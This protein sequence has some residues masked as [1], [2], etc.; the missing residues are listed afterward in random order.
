M[1]KMCALLTFTLLVLIF[2]INTVNAQD[3]VQKNWY[4]TYHHAAPA[5]LNDEPSGLVFFKDNYHL[6]YLHN[7]YSLDANKFVQG[8]SISPDMVNW[9]HLKTAVAPSER[10]DE[11]GTFSGSAIVKDDLLQLL[12]TGVE[13][14]ANG[15][16]QTQNLAVSKDGINFG[17]SAN[18]PVI[19]APPHYDYL[20]FSKKNFKDP[21]VWE[22]GERYYAVV[23]T[24]Y[25]K[26]NDGAVLLFKSKDLRNWSFINIVALGQKGEMGQVWESPN[27]IRIGSDDVLSFTTQGIKPNGKK[28]LNLYQSGWIIGSLDYNTG[29]FKQ[30]SPFDLFDYGFDFYAPQIVKT[31]DG[32]TVMIGHLG[33]PKS[34][35][36]EKAENWAGMMSVPRE[37]KIINGKII[38]TPITELKKLRDGKTAYANQT[39]ANE[40]EF[41]NV[42]G[43]VYEIETEVDLA[44]ANSF[45]LKFRVSDTQETVLTYN[46]ETQ[47]LI[48]NRDKSSATTLGITGER[49]VH[50]PLIKNE[51]G[52]NLLKLRIF[53]DKSSI[54]IFAND[55]QAVLS[56]RIYPNKNSN[57]IKISADGIAKIK[58]FDFYKLKN[59][60]E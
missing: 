57:D 50:L 60:G 40:R 4:P 26:T 52:E 31:K 51:A 10:Y 58:T 41:N 53:V 19:T 38:S 24:N 23:G 28:Y 1:K 44:K 33:M 55:G 39:I 37:L 2:S 9:T 22:K 29:N 30:K 15:A 3:A 42:K 18:N 21:Y 32:R 20:L 43:S 49:E 59:I 14:T 11:A 56:A 45:T 7:P 27:F 16:I 48:L 12:Y 17:K 36:P 54:E 47:T 25:E 34:P 13:E 5:S 6:F 46:K 8:H 35:M